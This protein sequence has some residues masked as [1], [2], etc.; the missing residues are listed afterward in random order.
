DRV[1]RGAQL[2]AHVREEHAL[3]P[4]RVLRAELRRRRLVAGERE[5]PVGLLDVAA[6]LLRQAAPGHEPARLPVRHDAEQRRV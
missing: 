2:V 3:R 1:E 5:Q 6:L 4:V